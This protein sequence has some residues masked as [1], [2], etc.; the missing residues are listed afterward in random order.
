MRFMNEAIGCKEIETRIM[1]GSWLGDGY[2]H[3]W[4][5]FTSLEPSASEMS[6]NPSK[7]K[8]FKS[9]ELNATCMMR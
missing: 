2:L 6:E 1:T 4:S 3:K 5:I 7:T 8:T 9:I